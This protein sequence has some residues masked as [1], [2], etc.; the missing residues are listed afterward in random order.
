MSDYG[1]LL[2]S[3][4]PGHDTSWI[5]AVDYDCLSLLVVGL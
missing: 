3:E 5:D 2:G 1:R 4:C